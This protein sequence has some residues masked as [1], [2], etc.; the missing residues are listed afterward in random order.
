MKAIKNILALTAFSLVVLALPSIASAQWRDRNGGNYGNTGYY[1]NIRQNIQ[2]IKNRAKTFERLADRRNDRSDDR[3]G[4]RGDYNNGNL[5]EMAR[6]FR[7]AIDNLG[8]AYNS[9]RD[10]GRSSDEAR[11]VLDLGAQISQQVYRS[12]VNNN[13]RYEWDQINNDLDVIAAAYGYTNNGRNGNR[14]RNGRFPY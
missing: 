7:N 8:R 10:Q 4:N 12:R 1:G 3:W 14:N 2:N 13:M 11:R 5:E 6:S 9:G